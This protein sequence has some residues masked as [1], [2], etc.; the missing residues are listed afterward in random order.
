MPELS[1]ILTA[2]VGVELSAPARDAFA[3]LQEHLRHKGIS[4]AYTSP[5][6]AHITVVFLGRIPRR[7][8]HEIAPKLDLAVGTLAP[9]T[10][11]PGGAGFFGP[12]R[13]PRIAWIGVEASAQLTDLFNCVAGIVRDA[14]VTLETRPFHPHLTLARIKHP[15][16]PASLTLIKT[17][18]NN[19]TFPR[20]PVDRVMFMSSQPG[21]SGPIHSVIHTSQLKGK[22][23]HG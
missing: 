19:T 17:S 11:L 21:N 6:L 5:A 2:F 14:G 23:D 4:V 22:H 20:V 12:P 13:S 3:Q 16:P 10:F 1:D 15:L 8:A 9:F 18:I 7:L